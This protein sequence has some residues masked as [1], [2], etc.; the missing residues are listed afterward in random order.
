MPYYYNAL[1]K[2]AKAELTLSP[3]QDWAENGAEV[4]SL[5]FHGDRLNGVTPMSVILNGSSPVYHDNPDVTRIGTWTEWI[6]DLQAFTGVDL[7]SVNSIAICLGDPSNTQA[8]G[9][10]KMFF[11]SIRLYGP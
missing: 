6:I 8:G 10:G 1:F 7:A 3:P 4:L 2:L 9:T 5:W 11:D